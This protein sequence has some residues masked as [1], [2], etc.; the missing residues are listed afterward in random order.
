M[1]GGDTFEDLARYYDPIMEHVHYERW[2]KIVTLLGA[3]LPP[4]FRHL[5]VAC[6]TGVLAN[7]LRERAWDSMGV[8]L[9]FAMLR[10]ARRNHRLPVAAADMRALPVRRMDFVT[11]LFDSVNF[12]LDETDLFGALQGFGALL[13]ENGVLYFDVVTERMVTEHF[14]GQDW[15]EDNGHFRSSWS[16]TYD[17]GTSITE[18]RIRINSGAE[19]I[20]YERIYPTATILKALESAG[21]SVLGA[22]DA[23][24]W[25]RP[26]VRTTRIDIVA[27]KTP[28]KTMLRRFESVCKA[29]RELK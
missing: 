3:M 24:T 29:V 17:R 19:S 4:H 12:L 16:S 11:C 2:L 15:T 8:D 10:T 7:M 6:G 5:D 1:A 25:K 26:N 14:E 20:L 9:S 13:P 18:T 27:A 23:H 22:L 28:A 21:L